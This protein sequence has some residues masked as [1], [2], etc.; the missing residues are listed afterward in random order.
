MTY[1]RI[2]AELDDDLLP[3]CRDCHDLIHI[4]YPYTCPENTVLFLVK[5][6]VP[7]C[8]ETPAALTLSTATSANA[9][10]I[11]A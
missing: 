8:N 4:E 3:L 5:Y 9:V 11:A 1:A 2:G 6:Q 10:Q 7:A